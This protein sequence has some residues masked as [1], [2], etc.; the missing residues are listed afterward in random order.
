MEYRDFTGPEHP[1]IQNNIKLEE[2]IPWQ[3]KLQDITKIWVDFRELVQMMKQSLSETERVLFKNR[4]EHWVKLYSVTYLAKD[5]TYYM[6]VMS[7]H[8]PHVMAVHGSLAP[9]CQQTF[10]KLNDQ[11]KNFYFRGS[12]H[13]T[14][15]LQ[16]FEQIMQKLNRVS[17]LFL[18]CQRKQHNTTVVYV[19]PKGIIY[20]HVHVLKRVVIWLLH[21]EFVNFPLI[22][23]CQQMVEKTIIKYVM[24][25]NWNS[26]HC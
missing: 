22:V 25:P 9:F 26:Q 15:D 2:L 23:F 24:I 18:T 11:L 16:S 1:K 14:K 8:V 5:I 20:E 3:N 6:H 10:E 4:A 17:F 19:A 7:V 13:K 12:D 21:A